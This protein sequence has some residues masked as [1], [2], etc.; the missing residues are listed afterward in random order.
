MTE[1]RDV[2][3]GRTADIA[4]RALEYD[5]C[6]HCLGR[7]FARTG[8]GLTNEE[9]GMA[10]R[11]YLAMEIES[12]NG[13]LDIDQSILEKLPTHARCESKETKIENE[14]K[15][16]DGWINTDTPSFNSPWEKETEPG[17]CWICGDVFD[18]ID[19]L[20]DLVIES[21]RGLDFETFQI[22][23]RIDPHTTMKEQSLWQELEPSSPEPIKE[24][25][26]RMIGKS[27]SYKAPDKIFE[28]AD[29][30]VAFIIDP[31]Y[32][33]VSM[34]IKPLFVFG[35]YRKLVRGI[36]QTRWPC[37]SCRGKGCD[38]CG[39]TGR[40]YET[41]VE[42]LIGTHGKEML[43][44]EDFK[45]HGMGREDVDVLSLGEGRPFII[46]FSRPRIRKIDLD[47]FT[48]RVNENSSGKIEVH[49]LRNSTR[50]EVPRVKEGSSKKS[51]RAT[52]SSEGGFDEE[53]LK[54][55]ISLLA[56]SPI[57]QRTPTRV[58][59]RRADKVRTRKI[60]E[61]SSKI[62]ENGSALIELTSDGGLYIKELLHGD[63]G[64]TEP[65]LCSLLERE[66]IVEKLDVT[67][68]FYE[69]EGN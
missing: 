69:D 4:L 68:V 21:S 18:H 31:L 42:E 52:I 62:L 57:R 3:L 64:R 55:N 40:M 10:I 56:Q 65:S 27:F 67:G 5:I 20:S 11:T 33:T 17:K 39:G 59:H 38:S 34:Q 61:I 43:D 48:K 28:R 47:E 53:T 13:D 8:Y 50:K 19:E 6:D 23:C 2:E 32:R 58:A 46:E 26:N 25:L 12:T 29:P 60:Y 1:K 44:S 66:I 45:L 9:R 41:S 22:G 30:D 14:E 36:P 37:R 7:L 16:D 54:Y 24:E 51:Y 15:D 49:S 63:D 35:R